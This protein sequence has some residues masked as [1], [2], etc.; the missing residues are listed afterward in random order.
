MPT[1]ERSDCQHQWMIEIIQDLIFYSR[2]NGLKVSEDGLL[3]AVGCV[4]Y[5]LKLIEGAEI[6]AALAEIKR[7]INAAKVDGDSP[8]MGQ[9][10]YLN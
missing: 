9:V 2:D 7:D 1:P 6:E 4:M 5:D 10:I 3:A 8:A